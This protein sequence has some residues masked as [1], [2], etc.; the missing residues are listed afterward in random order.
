MGTVDWVV[1]DGF[2]DIIHLVLD[3]LMNRNRDGLFS[4][5]GLAAAVG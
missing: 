5:W 3:V 4:R 2:S 1:L